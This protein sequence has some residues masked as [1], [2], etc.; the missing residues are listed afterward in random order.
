MWMHEN[1]GR[2]DHSKLRYPAPVPC[3]TPRA[4]LILS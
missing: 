1:R 4:S 2:Y 3:V